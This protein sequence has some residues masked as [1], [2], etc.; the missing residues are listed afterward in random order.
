MI[1]IDD[2]ALYHGHRH[3]DGEKLGGGSHRPVGHS[4]NGPALRAAFAVEEAPGDG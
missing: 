2:P 4:D 3:A 1:R